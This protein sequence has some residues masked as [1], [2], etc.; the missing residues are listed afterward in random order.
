VCA[1]DEEP[2]VLI[3]TSSCNI[4]ALF[5]VSETQIF[6]SAGSAAPVPVPVPGMRMR[7]E[8][9]ARA[10]I[11]CGNVCGADDEPG[12]LILD[13]LCVACCCCMGEKPFF[14]PP[15]CPVPALLLSG[16]CTACLLQYIGRCGC[17]L[18]RLSNSYGKYFSRGCSS[19]DSDVEPV[20]EGHALKSK[21]VC[22]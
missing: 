1:T 12:V 17:S 6:H 10:G 11:L 5:Y 15:W 7:T 9:A 16:C 22:H 21:V 4:L 8:G 20:G 2:W 19:I 13:L 14:E 3:F 18:R